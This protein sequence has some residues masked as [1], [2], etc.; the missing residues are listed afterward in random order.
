MKQTEF[1]LYVKSNLDILQGVHPELVSDLDQYES[2]LGFH[3]PTSMRWLLSVY[4]YSMACGIE[5]LEDSVK[6]TLDCRKSI[7]LPHNILLINDWGDGGVVFAIADNKPENDYEIIWADAFALY[8]LI[9]GEQ[10]P[11]DISRFDNFSAWVADR[12]EFERENAC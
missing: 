9:D 4:G 8:G 6:Q 1:E 5:N 12:V 3:L 7:S 10:L 11:E 2:E